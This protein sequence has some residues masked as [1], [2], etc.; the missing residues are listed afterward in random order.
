MG[1]PGPLLAQRSTVQ[2][3]VDD[4]T[5]LVATVSIPNTGDWPVFQTISTY[6]FLRPVSTG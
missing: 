3:Y 1:V 4:G 5:T 6:V 2:V